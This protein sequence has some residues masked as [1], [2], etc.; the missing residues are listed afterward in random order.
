MFLLTGFKWILK[1]KPSNISP[2]TNLHHKKDNKKQP[3]QFPN[4]LQ[5]FYNR[6]DIFLPPLSRLRNTGSD[7]WCSDFASGLLR[8]SGPTS[9]GGDKNLSSTRTTPRSGTRPETCSGKLSSF[10]VQYSGSRLILSHLDRDKLITIT[11][12]M[13]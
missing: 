3:V 2:W 8:S 1:H 6:A 13:N 12:W 5:T 7:I 4:L 10:K 9:W 11:D